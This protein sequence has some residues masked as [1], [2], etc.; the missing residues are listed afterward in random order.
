MMTSRPAKPSHALITPG[1]QQR[2]FTIRVNINSL[3]LGHSSFLP[4]QSVPLEDQ[5]SDY[6]NRIAESVERLKRGLILYR[7]SEQDEEMYKL[8]VLGWFKET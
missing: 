3:P 4:A 2:P 8:N 6:S 7:H 1:E 5:K